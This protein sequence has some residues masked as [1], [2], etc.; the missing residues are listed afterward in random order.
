MP[1][2][3]APQFGAKVEQVR[4]PRMNDSPAASICFWLASDTILTSATTV[5]S[6]SWRQS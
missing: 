6:G 3:Y 1:R 5:T 4:M 2:S